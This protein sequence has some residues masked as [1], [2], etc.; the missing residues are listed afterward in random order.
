[1]INNQ[2]R[3]TSIYPKANNRCDWMVY[4]DVPHL[5]FLQLSH[6]SMHSNSTNIFILTYMWYLTKLQIEL[7]SNPYCANAHC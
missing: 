7:Q 2:T 1:M 3:Q 4:N 6:W 5:K